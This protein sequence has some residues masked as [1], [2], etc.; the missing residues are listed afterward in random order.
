MSWDDA[1]KYCAK[2][3]ER[4]R[5]AGRLPADWK[6]DLPTEAQWEYACRAGTT[7]AYSFGDDK[8]K[9]GEY[10]WFQK[11]AYGVDEMYAHLVG[12]K[13][14]NAWGLYDMHGNVWEWCRDGYQQKLP[15]GT[16]PEAPAAAIRMYRGGGWGY[17]VSSCRSAHRYGDAP[18]Y[19]FANVGFRP[20]IVRQTK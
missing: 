12:L 20:V 11:N 9:M 6:Y 5:A 8:S 15:G 4:E 1:V 3:T 13:K 10:A 14:P 16:D 2:L 18:D 7:T 17:L 19:R